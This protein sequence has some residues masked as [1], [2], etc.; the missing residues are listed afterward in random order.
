MS[1]QLSG[2]NAGPK[3]DTGVDVLVELVDRRIGFQVK[4]YHFD[5]GTG[6]SSLRGKE[7]GKAAEG[8]PASHSQWQL[9]LI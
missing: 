3:A 8:L 7:S 2:P 4:Q 9:W 1:G 6:G 5:T